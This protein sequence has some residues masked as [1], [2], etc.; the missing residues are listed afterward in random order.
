M[1]ILFAG[2]GRLA[3]AMIWRG[4]VAPNPSRQRPVERQPWLRVQRSIRLQQPVS[5][6]VQLRASSGM[7]CAASC[8]SAPTKMKESSTAHLPA[9]SRPPDHRQ[10]LRTDAVGGRGL[11]RR[12]F[13]PPIQGRQRAAGAFGPFRGDAA[14]GTVYS[15]APAVVP[16]QGAVDFGRSCARGMPRNA[17][18]PGRPDLVQR[19]CHGSGPGA[20]TS[21]CSL[22]R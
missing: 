19:G 9:S 20:F 15:A 22:R 1:T 4:Q 8:H 6:Q 13:I 18:P 7:C 21:G 2:C 14:T 17:V 5:F 3:G 16:G 11:A 10:V 12:W